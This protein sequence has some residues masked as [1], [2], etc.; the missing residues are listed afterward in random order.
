M[1]ATQDAGRVIRL[2][3]ERAA[4]THADL[5]ARA[6]R[7]AAEVGH[8][9]HLSEHE[10]EAVEVGRAELDDGVLTIIAVAAGA[11]LCRV[12]GHSHD[13]NSPEGRREQEDQ[14]SRI[15]G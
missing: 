15:F 8:A 9:I 13:W 7:R 2:A 12:A 5:A 4:M 6:V 1:K 14:L 10:I 3:R 11:D